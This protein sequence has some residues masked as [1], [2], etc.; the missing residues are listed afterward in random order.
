MKK[1]L[2]LFIVFALVC[3]YAVSPAQASNTDAGLTSTL[4]K[5]VNNDFEVDASGWTLSGTATCY[6]SADRVWSGSKSLYVDASSA[7]SFSQ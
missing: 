4:S 5:T 7:F 6:S 2:I 1:F 3:S